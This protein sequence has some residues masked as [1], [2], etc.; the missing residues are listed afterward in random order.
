MKKRIDIDKPVKVEPKLTEII[1]GQ[2][3]SEEII[4]HVK[5]HPMTMYKV[6]LGLV[7]GAILVV[8]GYT[9]FGASAISSLITG[10]YLVIGGYHGFINWY[11]WWAS[12]YLLTT[13]RAISVDQENFFHRIVKEAPL[14][15][16]QNVFFEI[17]GPYQTFLNYG[18]VKILTAGQNDADIKFRS[19]P[20][21]YDIQQ[22]ITD[23]AYK[24]GNRKIADYKEK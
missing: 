14:D 9:L 18:T 21:P 8:L 13:E 22:K 6:G 2:T 3:P 10:L 12:H 15:K 1:E 16:I 17:K 4:F 5:R 11:K 20:N 7:G 24:Y 19:I 23:I